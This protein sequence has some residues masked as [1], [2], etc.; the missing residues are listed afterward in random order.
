MLFE[1]AQNGDVGSLITSFYS[2]VEQA[3]NNGTQNLIG[4]V[5][6]VFNF[7]LVLTIVWT[8]IMWAVSESPIA[9]SIIRRLAFISI[10]MFFIN[11]WVDCVDAIRLTFEQF[12][13]RVDSTNS[14]LVTQLFNEPGKIMGFGAK[15]AQPILVH[16]NMVGFSQTHMQIM[17]AFTYFMI[18]GFWAALSFVVLLNLVIFKIGGV[19]AYVLLPFAMFD[20]TSFLAERPISW[21]FS[22]GTRIMAYAMTLG[23]SVSFMQDSIPKLDPNTL[24]IGQAI[25]LLIISGLLGVFVIFC[26]KIASNIGG[27]IASLGLRD[28]EATKRAST[29]REIQVRTPLQPVVYTG[30]HDTTA[31]IEDKGTLIE[32]YVSKHR[33]ASN[34][35][36]R[37]R[38]LAVLAKRYRH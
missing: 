8:G 15:T 16:I 34:R 6:Y 31:L 37:Q 7:L 28:T 25:E 1:I 4:D 38:E 14:D 33:A 9:P 12:G 35:Y 29:T 11:N 17:M 13:L 5:T 23:I 22:A 26:G 2:T 32:G 18:L 21:V 24:Q 27:G 10:L 19:I 20:K 3:I 30:R 36:E